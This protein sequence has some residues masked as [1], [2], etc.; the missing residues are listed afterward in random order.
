MILGHV[1]AL[2]AFAALTVLTSG[3]W[4]LI[5]TPLAALAGV[6]PPALQGIMSARVSADAQGELHGALSSSTALTM[7]LSPL[8]MT[9]VFAYFTAPDTA[10]YLPGAPF[11]LAL[12]LTLGGLVIFASRPPLTSQTGTSPH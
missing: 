12:F 11:L 8:T 1:F 3:T 7:I 4:A 5:M 10:L 6:I 9:A 2:A